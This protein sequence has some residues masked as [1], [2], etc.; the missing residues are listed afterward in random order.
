MY[1][2][3]G[4]ASRCVSYR[5]EMQI[6][7]V[8]VIVIASGSVFK[9]LAYCTARWLLYAFLNSDS[10]LCFPTDILQFFSVVY[11]QKLEFETRSENH[12]LTN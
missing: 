7:N 4:Y 10:K 3:V 5:H 11:T 9:N 1:R 6:P 12:E 2:I 8:Y